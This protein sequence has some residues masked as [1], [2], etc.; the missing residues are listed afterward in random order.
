V[1]G[2]G[3][4]RMIFFC[5]GF[6]SRFADWCDAVTTRLVRCALGPTEVIS[7]NSLEELAIAAIRVGPSHLVVC[8]RQPAGRVAMV[9]SEAQRRFIAVLD[10]P[11]AAVQDL[12]SRPGYDLVA[13]TRAVASSCA[14]LLSYVSMP[15]G[16]VLSAGRDGH[17]PLATA[18]TIARHLELSVD[19]ADIAH[20]VD[21]LNESIFPV[22]SDDD[23]WWG[24]LEESERD[25]ING[26]LGAYVENFGGGNL[27]KIT[28]ERALFFISDEP[29]A[30]QPVPATRPVDI[31]G[32]IRFLVYGPFI[33]LPQ[34]SWAASVVLGLSPEATGIA[35]I[36]EIFAGTRLAHVRVEPENE[37]VVELNL[38]FA[39]DESV[40][41]PVQIRIHT[42]RPAFDGRLAVGY[43]TMTP[44]ADVRPGTRTYLTS[45][46]SQ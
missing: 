18:M 5:I 4:S 29:P 12:L 27:G 26:A 11:R 8:S 20:I 15:G 7:L 23:G 36:V 14:S 41:Q 21:T 31:T 44:Q 32:R 28:W 43:V 22:R 2:D 33:N 10:E 45:V 3:R 38:H 39:I 19:P 37:G 42:E 40:D 24:R 13:A 16:L 30:P 25:L 6:P 35:Y 34:G 1:I 46:L 17:D 9:L